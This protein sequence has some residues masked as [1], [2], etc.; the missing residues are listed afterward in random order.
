MTKRRPS[1]LMPYSPPPHRRSRRTRSVRGKSYSSLIGLCF[2]LSISFSFPFI[3]HSLSHSLSMYFYGDD[4][5]KKIFSK[6][7]FRV[8][9]GHLRARTIRLHIVVLPSVRVC[10]DRTTRANKR[11]N[12]AK[13]RKRTLGLAHERARV[14]VCVWGR[15]NQLLRNMRITS[16]HPNTNWLFTFSKIHKFV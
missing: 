5:H 11:N 6:R 1:A 14:C 10:C 3:Y 9:I 13:R 4:L 16:L 2:Y 15:G 8:W 7:N 12:M